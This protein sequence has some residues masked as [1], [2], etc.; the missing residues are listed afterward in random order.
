MRYSHLIH[1]FYFPG[2]L[3]GPY[4][5]YSSYMSLVDESIYKVAETSAN[6]PKSGRKVPKGRK[7][8][9]Y[10]KM[11][12][13]LGFL[14][15]FVTLSGSYNFGVAIQP[16]FSARGLLFRSISVHL[17]VAKRLAN[18]SIIFYWLELG[19][20]KYAVSSK[21]QNIMLYGLWPRWS[22]VKSI[23]LGITDHLN[24]VPVYSLD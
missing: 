13:G 6:T 18:K 24:R 5:E 9:A 17:N 4:L 19:T 10:R 7:R 11:V 22:L 23:N 1:R 3:V 21:G 16:W 15:L 2:F 14:G 20:S 8:V 12:I